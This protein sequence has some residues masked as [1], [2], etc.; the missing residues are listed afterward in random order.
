M[1]DA[2]RW[3]KNDD[4]QINEA[5]N[6][7]TSVAEVDP[8]I[9]SLSRALQTLAPSEFPLTKQE[10]LPR[11]KVDPENPVVKTILCSPTVAQWTALEAGTLNI[12]EL[13]AQ[14]GYLIDEETV[15][16][17]GLRTFRVVPDPQYV[18]AFGPALATAT[19]VALQN[20]DRAISKND[21][22]M[23]TL[24]KGLNVEKTHRN[25]TRVNG[26]RAEILMHQGDA[27]PRL[28]H[29]SLDYLQRVVQMW[30]ISRKGYLDRKFDAKF[31]ATNESAE[32]VYQHELQLNQ[33]FETKMSYL[34]SSLKS[35][36]DQ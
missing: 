5:R 2:L 26:N 3:F 34:L 20:P 16:A 14:E 12:Q 8:K 23:S 17:N 7:A 18:E 19:L 24:P 29:E 25:I 30:I 22:R 9:S 21:F 11:L 32:K 35:P 6:R 36:V 15:Q 33:R 10:I 1:L 27:L 31:R 28:S 13:I 4:D